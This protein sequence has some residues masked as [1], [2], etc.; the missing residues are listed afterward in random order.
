LLNMA[1]LANTMRPIMR[2]KDINAPFTIV[3]IIFPYMIYQ[4]YVVLVIRSMLKIISKNSSM[5]QIHLLSII[6]N[7]KHKRNK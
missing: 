3:N 6:Q 2:N 7:Y 1:I 4:F 5:L